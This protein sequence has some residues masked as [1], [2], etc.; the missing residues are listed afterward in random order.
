MAHQKP[1]TAFESLPA[2]QFPRSL[3]GDLRR[4]R[5]TKGLIALKLCFST[6]TS[7][8]AAPE[9][10]PGLGRLSLIQALRLYLTDFL[11]RTFP[12]E[13]AKI[14]AFSGGEK[15]KTA[16]VYQTRI[17]HDAGPLKSRLR[18]RCLYLSYS[19]TRGNP[20]G[21]GAGFWIATAAA[22]PRDEGKRQDFRR[23]V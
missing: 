9:T 16:A 17:K 2:L 23:L 20:S 18:L 8:S 19:R 10:R 6:T 14:R 4:K 1:V 7:D 21:A 12:G 22:P 13:N 15:L 3:S 11:N 5:L